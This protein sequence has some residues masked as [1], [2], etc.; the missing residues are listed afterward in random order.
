MAFEV[1]DSTKDDRDWITNLLLDN[2]VSN[3]IVTRGITYEA[4]KLPA[5][6]VEVDSLRVGLL[7]YKI[8]N[9]ELEIITMNA[10]E[11]HQGVGTALLNEVEKIA[12]Q[13]GCERIWLITTNDNIDALRFYQRRGFEMVAVH[14]YA[15][16]ESRKLKPQL[17]FVGK[18]GIPIRDEIEM[19]LI[20]NE[21]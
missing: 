14:R 4:D 20:L 12:R 7:T 18:H 15:I 19:E 1:R 21:K 16:E 10:L 2:W 17:P 6:I 3:I 11:K 13:N 8:K 9:G 5:I